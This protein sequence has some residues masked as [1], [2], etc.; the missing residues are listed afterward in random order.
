MSYVSSAIYPGIP[1]PLRLSGSGM[2]ILALVSMLIDHA[3]LFLMDQESDIYMIS[4]TI[5]RIAMP[6]FAYLIAEGFAHSHNRLKYFVT[7]VAF[8]ILSDVPWTLLFQNDGTHNILF[9]FALGIIALSAF[10]RLREHCLMTCTA[11]IVIA[12]IATLFKCDY[13]WR[14]VG[15]VSVFYMLRSETIISWRV[16]RGL[17]L[18]TQKLR[19]LL[20]A[21]PFML[22]GNIVGVLLASAIILLYDGNRGFVSGNCMRYFFYSIYPLQFVLFYLI[23][24][25]I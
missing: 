2:K 4:R 8:A 25:N 13:G 14:S 1:L 23:L 6:V 22:D 9:T 19:Q 20:F 16:C 21:W 7:V 10:E 11:I 5:G 15:L 17:N 3:A 18:L 12:G 24:T